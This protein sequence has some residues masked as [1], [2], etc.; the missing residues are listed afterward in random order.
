MKYL[1]SLFLFLIFDGLNAQT[2]TNN[3]SDLFYKE[4]NS[5]SNPQNNPVN[6]T[7]NTAPQ[8]KKYGFEK[9]NFSDFINNNKPIFYPENLR[10]LLKIRI[11]MGMI[12]MNYVIILF[13]K[14]KIIQMN[15]ERFL[16]PRETFYIFQEL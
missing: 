10:S 5:N 1:L 13:M 14:L 2:V 11:I 6:K 7:N 3:N 15:F 16:L 4:D 12:K 9:T 8:T